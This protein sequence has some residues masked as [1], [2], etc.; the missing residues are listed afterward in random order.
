MISA[1][2][3]ADLRLDQFVEV[4]HH[5]LIGADECSLPQQHGIAFLLRQGLPLAVRDL[6]KDFGVERRH[7]VAVRTETGIEAPSR[8]PGF[9]SD[10]RCRGQ[11]ADQA[12]AGVEGQLRRHVEF[13]CWLLWLGRGFVEEVRQQLGVVL[14]RH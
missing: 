8:E 10:R 5:V 11:M 4:Q 7:P 13:V 1:E 2:G 12:I 3:R 9:G 14:E 6:A